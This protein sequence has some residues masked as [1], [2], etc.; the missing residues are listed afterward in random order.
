MTDLKLNYPTI[1]AEENVLTNFIADKKSLFKD[2][3]SFPSYQ[4]KEENLKIASKWL[5]I[6]S[7]TNSNV[8]DI[9][10]CNSAN[11]S[12]SCLVQILKQ[13]HQ[14]IITEPFTYPAFKTIALKNGFKLLPS[15]FDSKGLTVE[16]LEKIYAL[17]KSRLIYLQPTIHNP[18]CVVMPLERRKIIAAFARQNNI[19][20]IED[21]AYRFLHPNPPLRFLDLAPENT[22]HIFSLSKPFNPFI[23]TS[24]LITPTIFKNSITESVKLNSSGHSSLLSGMAAYILDNNILNEIILQK[25]RL[26]IQLQ[27]RFT[28]LIK[29]LA[30]QTFYTSFHIWVKLPE[31]I[32]SDIVVSELSKK[33]ILISNGKDF[34]VKNSHKGGQ[35]IRISLSAENSIYKIEKAL[36][37]IANI[38]NKKKTTTNKVHNQWR[39]SV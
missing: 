10:E 17:T 21:D 22:F 20:I 6:E 30:F 28:P 29:D 7:F 38:I 5:N 8:L 9:V 26:A 19:L 18:T 2:F 13:T 14:S 12:L 27:E 11:H 24:F 39:G 3:L 4:G 15:D 31:K 35:F 36:M 25:Q 16:G 32:K 37:E 1:D 23:K 34:S 33:N